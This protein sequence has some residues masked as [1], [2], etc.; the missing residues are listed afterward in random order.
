MEVERRVEMMQVA[1]R[2]RK[3]RPVLWRKQDLKR[4]KCCSWSLQLI[5]TQTQGEKYNLIHQYLKIQ[6]RNRRMEVRLSEDG[7]SHSLWWAAALGKLSIIPAH[8][9]TIEQSAPCQIT[10]PWSL[11]WLSGWYVP[12]G[13]I[14]LVSG[15]PLRTTV[16]MFLKIHQ[17]QG[18]YLESGIWYMWKMWYFFSSFFASDI[19]KIFSNNYV[20]SP[21]AP[22]EREATSDICSFQ[23]IWKKEF[24]CLLSFFKF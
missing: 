10:G 13:Q 2:A 15:Q 11:T 8:K 21:E 7:R 24:T 18:L 5:A 23:L 20:Q 14:C 4:V 17:Q 12:G 3:A 22:V 1:R 9:P 6:L 19:W 16:E